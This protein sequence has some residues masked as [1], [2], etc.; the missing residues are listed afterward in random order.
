MPV[1]G[2]TLRNLF[3]LG[4]SMRSVGRPADVRQAVY[5]VLTE[6]NVPLPFTEVKKRT[7]K[8]LRRRTIDDRT[9]SRA[10][11]RLIASTLVE[12]VV[13]G[14]RKKYNVI[15]KI[16][17]TTLDDMITRMVTRDTTDEIEK[18]VDD[19]FIH[20]EIPHAVFVVPPQGAPFDLADRVGRIASIVSWRDPA[21]GIA[22]LLMNDLQGLDP[23]TAHGITELVVWAYWTGVREMIENLG[24]PGFDL[25]SVIAKNK[26]FLSGIIKEALAKNDQV[27][28]NTETAILQIANSTEELAN[29]HDLAEFVSF[30][31]LQRSRVKELQKR[32]LDGYGEF[33]NAGEEVFDKLTEDVGMGILIGFESAGQMEKLKDLIPLHIQSSSRVWTEFG[34]NLLNLQGWRGELSNVKGN[35]SESRKRIHELSTH[36]PALAN[37]LK[38]R[39][40]AALY[41]WGFPQI[42]A[43]A[44]KDYNFSRFEDWMEALQ[45]GRI[46]H[47]SWLFKEETFKDLHQAYNAVKE[48]QC[49]LPAQID[50]EPWTLADLWKYHPDGKKPEFW[51]GLMDAIRAR[52]I[53][54]REMDEMNSKSKG[55]I[56]EFRNK[57]SAFF[58][59]KLDEHRR[60]LRRKK[61]AIKSKGLADGEGGTGP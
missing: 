39:R 42:D 25:L 36:L 55:I 27:R 20:T 16:T 61:K 12:A 32:V 46:D 59:Q 21:E 18:T 10:L 40:V 1:T 41:L 31:T 22:S 19:G 34:R 4:N 52:V 28:V 17:V 35:L 44:E 51:E 47:R 9:V 33:T 56:A 30:Y 58:G 24:G 8:L 2:E 29:K 48:G 7:S 53:P 23:K 43:G 13:E 45:K 15:R 14:S 5:T 26:A 50:K 54:V 38:K 11:G 49:P 37:L 6:S 57:E 60:E 3:A